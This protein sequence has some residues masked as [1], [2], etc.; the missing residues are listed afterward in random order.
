MAAPAATSRPLSFRAP[1]SKVIMVGVSV[2]KHPRLPGAPSGAA[3]SVPARNCARGR[4]ALLV[5]R[6]AP[7][8]WRFRS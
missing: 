4:K 5:A 2:P 3:T 1:P 6:H 8:R 7:R